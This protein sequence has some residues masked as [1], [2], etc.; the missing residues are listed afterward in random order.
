M[1][2]VDSTVICMPL[3]MSDRQEFLAQ[4][5]VAALSVDAG[6]GRG[7]LSVPIWYYFVLGD[8]PWVLSPPESRKSALIAAAGRFTLLVHRTVPTVR[9]VSVEGVVI[10]TRPATEDQVRL[11][12]VR[13]LPAERVEPYVEFAHAEHIIRMKPEHWL[14]ADLGP[15]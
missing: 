10:D 3:S 8:V 1:S 13:Y 15:A 6:P 9:Y 14:S 11:I 4:P 12:A 7:P 2:A 5:H